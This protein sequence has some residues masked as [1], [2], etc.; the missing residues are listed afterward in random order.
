MGLLSVL[1]AWHLEDSVDA[2]ELRRNDVVFAYQGNR[3][4]FVDH[5]EWA[6]VVFDRSWPGEVAPFGRG[7]RAGGA[8]PAIASLGTPLIGRTFSLLLAGAPPL[9]PAVVNLDAQARFIEI[10]PLGLG[11]ADCAL[12]ALPLFGRSG[13][14]D[15]AGSCSASI[16]VPDFSDLVGLQLYAQ[17]VV[18]DGVAQSLALSNGA[19]LSI[20]RP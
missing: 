14:T 19:A 3:N 18:R 16:P 2:D 7:C 13:M 17:W 10:L 20:G 11:G 5:P 4:P 12:L 1:L 8:S 15:G 6:S 9:E